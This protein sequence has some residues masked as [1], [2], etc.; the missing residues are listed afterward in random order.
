VA[1]VDD[2]EK[3][4]AANKRR[5]EW[6]RAT[7]PYV[8]QNCGIGWRSGWLCPRCGQFGRINPLPIADDPPPLRW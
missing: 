8:C 4:K 7:M 6:E 1:E 3:K 5:G 2:W